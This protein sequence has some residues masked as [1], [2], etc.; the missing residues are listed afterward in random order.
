[1]TGPRATASLRD[2]RLNPTRSGCSHKRVADVMHSRAGCCGSRGDIRCVVEAHGRDA[3]Q[4]CALASLDNK[5]GH[6]RSHAQDQ[7]TGQQM[8]TSA[9]SSS[10]AHVVV[11]GLLLI[12]AGPARAHPNEEHPPQ[13]N[14]VYQEH[15]D[16]VTGDRYPAA[17]LMSR[18]VVVVP[19]VAPGPGDG[20]LA[21]GN[22]PKRPLEVTLSL[23]EPMTRENILVCKLSGCELTVRFG[24]GAAKKFVA[25]Q[26]KA[27]SLL[28]VQDGRALVAEATRQVGSIEI[29]VKTIGD[30]LVTLQFLT[31]SRLQLEKL[32]KVTK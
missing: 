13:R 5:F 32:G 15:A 8:I 31:A 23:D 26:G 19:S 7:P 9:K 6:V 20:Y 14:W 25:V 27:P 21:V 16:I 2:D 28:V 11:L 12:T 24:S 10:R 4:D 29:Q 3:L 30:E 17:L 1:M 18:K 22:Y